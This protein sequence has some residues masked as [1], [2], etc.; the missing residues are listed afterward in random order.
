MMVD[1]GSCK[2]KAHPTD[3]ENSESVYDEFLRAGIKSKKE[4]LTAK[5]IQY[6]WQTKA[7]IM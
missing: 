6:T 4:K 1:D 7:T 5:Q 3:T 2:I